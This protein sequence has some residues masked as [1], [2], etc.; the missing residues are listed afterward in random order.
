M[1]SAIR[2]V[3]YG[4]TAICGVSLLAFCY[5]DN[6]VSFPTLAD[7]ALFVEKLASNEKSWAQ[8]KLQRAH[9]D[10]PHYK[11][12]T[13]TIEPPQHPF[14]AAHPV[15]GVRFNEQPLPDV[16]DK[17]DYNA[18]RKLACSPQ[19]CDAENEGYYK[20][21]LTAVQNFCQIAKGKSQTNI[22]DVLGAPDYLCND[23]PFWPALKAGQ[24]LWVYDFGLS[25]VSVKMLFDGGVCIQCKI[26]KPAES[27]DLSHWL[28]Y[29]IIK[30]SIGNSIDVI[31]AK[32]GPPAMLFDENFRPILR[33]QNDE[34]IYYFVSAGNPIVL[35]IRQG[36]CV[37]VYDVARKSLRME[38]KVRP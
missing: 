23:V 16:L 15:L 2:F 33:H 12:F 32:N 1:K 25:P 35:S 3:I 20:A 29:R 38:R 7:K 22:R 4:L 10:D 6:F 28:E 17:I 14:Y 30:S 11:T 8:Y 13:D 31:V 9:R 37:G 5:Y 34:S 36:L 19:V 27:A 26:L 21:E 24:A 18:L